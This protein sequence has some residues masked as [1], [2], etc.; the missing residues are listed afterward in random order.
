MS[1]K[2]YKKIDVTTA[3]KEQVL[4]SL[5]RASISSLKNSI[6]QENTLSYKKECLLKAYSI[7][8][9]L[10]TSL[11]HSK[12]INLTK[13]LDQLYDFVLIQIEKSNM[14]ND[15]SGISSAIDILTNL[16]TSWDIII[17]KKTE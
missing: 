3:S 6:Q 13:Q 5:Y 17:N 10:K 1:I 12:D 4:L 7:I 11:D 15:Y 9:E 8:N 14:K 16:Y 2:Q